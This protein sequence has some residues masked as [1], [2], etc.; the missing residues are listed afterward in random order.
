MG[1]GDQRSKKGKR[2]RGTYGR[3]RPRPSNERKL[4]EKRRAEGSQDQ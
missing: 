4:K 1:K 3:T 2:H